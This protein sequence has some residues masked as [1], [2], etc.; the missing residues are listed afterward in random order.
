MVFVNR[1]FF[2]SAISFLTFDLMNGLHHVHAP[3]KCRGCAKYFL[4]TNGHMPK[5]CDG[6]APQDSRMTCRQYGAMMQQKEKNK[7]HPIYRLFSTRT[8]TSANTTREERSLM[9]CV[10]RLSM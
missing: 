8:N 4:T 9:S 2:E 5:Y 7:Q 6:I 10:R 3:S 1:Y